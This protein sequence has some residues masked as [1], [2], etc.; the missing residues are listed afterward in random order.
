MGAQPLVVFDNRTGLS[1]I[2][3]RRLHEPRNDLAVPNIVGDE[4]TSKAAHQAI[5]HRPIELLVAVL[6][7]QI[8]R[9]GDLG[10][11]S[12]GVADDD[13]GATG[14]PG[15][16]EML[17]R[18][19]CPL[20]VHFHCHQGSVS[21]QRTGQP[22]PPVADRGADLENAPGLN[23]GRQ[24]AQQHADFGI[25]E[26]QDVDRRCAQCLSV[27]FISLT[28][29]RRQVLLNGV[30]ND[31]PHNGKGLYMRRTKIIATVGPA[32]DTDGLLDA[33]VAAGVDIF[34]LNFSHGTQ[35]THAA[36]FHRIRAAAARAGRQVAILQ[37]LAGPKIRTGTLA[38]RPADCVDARLAA[39]DC[40][41]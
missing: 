22:D 31:L 40:D 1:G 24:H 8:E 7:N 2:A 26:R 20:F 13:A 29:E 15:P 19:A 39:C 9:P 27:Q 32:C 30:R 18:L 21:R 33:L 36:T 3:P 16:R 11:H 14:Q 10:Q 4:D 6:E 5:Q 35:E 23:G 28:V 38:R 17:A 41:R 25:D 34:R 37:D 12:L